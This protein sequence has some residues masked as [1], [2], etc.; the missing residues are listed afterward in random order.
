MIDELEQMFGCTYAE[1]PVGFI[2][3]AVIMCW[4]IKQIFGF[5]YWLL[6]GKK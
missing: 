3:C 2:V 1:N 6:G 5:A 4:M